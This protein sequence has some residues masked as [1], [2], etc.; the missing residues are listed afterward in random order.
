MSGGPTPYRRGFLQFLAGV[1][2]LSL[3]S[4]PSGARTDRDVVEQDVVTRRISLKAVS[5]G[6]RDEAL[7]HQIGW[8]E[9]EIIETNLAVSASDDVFI[10]V[11][12][13]EESYM[14]GG[15]GDGRYRL[16]ATSTDS[17][18]SDFV[19]RRDQM[20]ALEGISDADLDGLYISVENRNREPVD[21]TVDVQYTRYGERLQDSHFEVELLDT[22][23]PIVRGETVEARIRVTN[24]G[25]QSGRQTI[26]LQL[27][28]TVIDQH[29]VQLDPGESVEGVVGA[30]V[31]E[32]LTGETATVQVR[33]E[34]NASEERISVQSRSEDRGQEVAVSDGGSDESPSAN[35]GFFSNDANSD[36]DPV[37]G[38]MNLSVAGFLLS[39]AGIF[40]SLLRGG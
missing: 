31:R 16:D 27:E 7:I 12:P 25:E 15:D 30:T 18:S 22:S 38:Q 37:G 36:I 13:N 8:G 28:E 34:Q 1:S 11:F 29:T 23:E 9:T 26:E 21:V 40:I 5:N 35:R 24:T 2:V 33:S 20:V 6:Q 17:L 3:A 39:I 32:E 10:Q 19:Y 14:H 4:V